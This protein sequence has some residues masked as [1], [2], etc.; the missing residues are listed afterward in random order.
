MSDT[1]VPDMERIVGASERRLLERFEGLELESTAI[2]AG[3]RRV[4]E[5]LDSLVQHRELAVELRQLDDRLSRVEKR[6]DDLVASEHR[7]ALQTDVQTLRARVSVL[8]AQVTTLQKPL[9]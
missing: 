2:E 3:L 5:R 4:E 1:F 7:N 8:E 6:L 9:P